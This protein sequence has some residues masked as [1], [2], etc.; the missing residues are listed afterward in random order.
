MRLKWSSSFLMLGVELSDF[1]LTPA[2]KRAFNL[3]W[4]HLHPDQRIWLEERHYFPVIGN[5]TGLWY[6]LAIRTSPYCQS[7]VS[8]TVSENGKNNPS[9]SICLEADNEYGGLWLPL[10]DR[11]DALLLLISANEQYV[12]DHANSLIGGGC[13]YRTFIGNYRRTGDFRFALA[14]NVIRD[15][16]VATFCSLPPSGSWP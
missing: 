12:I 1:V 6:N 7:S 3:L 10:F 9:L 2:D 13:L 11:L 15:P 14:R 4:S 16:I 8:I 5:V